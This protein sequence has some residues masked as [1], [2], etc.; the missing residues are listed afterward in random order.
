MS[1]HDRSWIDI[2]RRTFTKW[3]NAHLK[4]AGHRET[5]EDLSRDLQDGKLLHKLLESISNTKLPKITMTPKMR[6]HQIQNLNVCVTFISSKV[7]LQGI[8]AEDICNGDIKLILGMIWMIILRFEIADISVEDMNAKEGLL[9]WCQKKTA[10]YP[11]VHVKNFTD[12]WQDGLAFCAL[13]HKHMPTALDFYAQSK[14]KPLENLELAFSVAEKQ[15]GIPRFFDPEDMIAADERSVM[16]YLLQFFHRFADTRKTEVAGRRISKL[17]GLVQSND[18]MKQAYV[19]KAT[20]L[21]AWMDIK[22]PELLDLNFDNTLA[23]ANGKQD[24][25]VLYQSGV[26]PEKAAEKM[27][28]EGL[29]GNLQ[30]KLR[31]AGR[32]EYVPP[33]GLSPSDLDAKWQKLLEA[34]ALKEKAIRDEIARQE[35]IEEL[36]R[37]FHE[38]KLKLDK[39]SEEKKTFLDQ[40]PV[41]DTLITAQSQIKLLDGYEQQ[42]KSSLSRVAELH[43][44]GDQICQL[45]A[46]VAPE[47]TQQVATV[48]ATWT[49]LSSKCE[50][51]K[52]WLNEELEKQ[53]RMEELRRLFAEKVNSLNKW[54]QD[55]IGAIGDAAFGDTL[56][57]VIAYKEKLDLQEMQL[58]ASSSEK[59]N[60]LEAIAN[61]MKEMGITENK[62]TMLTLDDMKAQEV[63][64][65]GAL[66]K[67]KEAYEAELKRQELMEEKR[68]EFAAAANKFM[69]F[70]DTQKNTIDA[71]NGEPDP[72]TEEIKNQWQEAAPQQEQLDNL[73]RL[74]REE[75]A[76]QITSNKYTQHTVASCASASAVFDAY[77][78]NYL[79][80]LQEEKALKIEFAERAARL[81]A[82]IVATVEKLGDR[83]FDNTLAG[84]KSAMAVFGGYRSGEKPPKT[85]EYSAVLT[86]HATIVKLL[87]DSPHHRPEFVPPEGLAPSDLKQLWMSLEEAETNREQFLTTELKRQERLNSIQRL[88]FEEAGEL[89]AWAEGKK[90]YLEV[91]VAVDTLIS[92]QIQMNLMETYEDDYNASKKKVEDLRKKHDDLVADNFCKTDLVKEKMAAIDASWAELA[93]LAADKKTKIEEQLSLEQRKEEQRLDFALLAKNFKEWVL[94]QCDKAAGTEFGEGLKA[95]EEFAKKLEHKNKKVNDG[96]KERL[97]EIHEKLHSMEELGVTDNVHTSIKSEDITAL[98]QKLQTALADRE[99]K[100]NQELAK[101]QAM[102]NKRIEFANAGLELVA[103]LVNELKAFDEMRGEPEPLT[104]EIK[105]R[106]NNGEKAAAMLAHCNEIYAVALRMEITENKHAKH[107]V[108]S[109]ARQV[110]EYNKFVNNFLSEL[111]NEKNEK[112]LYTEKATKLVEWAK[113]SIEE[114]GSR[115]IDNTLAGAQSKIGES[116]EW[117]SAVK[118]PKVAERTSVE[119]IFAKVNSIVTVSPHHRPEFNPA[120]EI[121]PAGIAA[122]FENLAQAEKE[123]EEFLTKEL[124]RQERL[125]RLARDFNLAGEELKSWCQQKQEYL[126]HAEVVDTLVSSKIQLDLL[127]TFSTE[128]ANSKAQLT[129]LAAQCDELAQGNYCEIDTIKKSLEEMTA[130]WESLKEGEAKKR[131]DL[132]KDEEREEKKEEERKAFAKLASEFDR[133]VR[134]ACDKI[135]KYAFGSSL[136]EVRAYESTMQANDSELKDECDKRMKAIKEVQD[137]MTELAVQDNVYTLLGMKEMDDLVHRVE[138]SIENRHNAYKVELDRQEEM[139]KTRIKFAELVTQFIECL[140]KGKAAIDA[141]T[142]EPEHKEEEIKRV[143]AGGDEQRAKLAD[144]VQLDAVAKELKIIDNK[145]TQFTLPMLRVKMDK[146]EKYFANS[147]AAVEQEKVMKQRKL[148]REAE[149]ALK[150]KIESLRNEYQNEAQTLNQWLDG[151]LEALAGTPK[152]SSEKEVDDLAAQLTATSQ[153][154][155]QQKAL[156]DKVEALVGQLKEAGVNA[157]DLGHARVIENWTACGAAIDARSQW[158]A[159]EK[160]TQITHFKLRTQYAELAASFHN[161]MVEQKSVALSG[162]L[163]V[164]LQ[165]SLSQEQAVRTKGAEFTKQAEALDASLAE[166]HVVGNPLTVHTTKSLKVEL[167]QLLDVLSKRRDLLERQINS[168]KFGGVS[169]EE[170]EEMSALFKQFDKEHT[171][172]LRTYMFKGIMNALGEEMSD[173]EIK[174]V[175]DSIDTNH[176]GFLSF[177]E[178]TTFMTKR[179]TDTDSKEEIIA[180]FRDITNGKDSITVNELSSVMPREQAEW[181]GS[182]MPQKEG[183]LD[184][185]AWADQAFM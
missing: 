125:T 106:Y 12:S 28:A 57:E 83:A 53:K 31:N 8:S 156:Y 37:L 153:E 45:G 111:D 82:W 142:G 124:E 61:Q 26:K 16:T 140:D 4:K 152:V 148:E 104:E 50:E 97:E 51:K 132:K 9:Y 136:E 151:V 64:M 59:Y 112:A 169:P 77:V 78:R 91:V 27:A 81:K 130:L 67:L 147:M 17:V 11:G 56:E 71:L 174:R 84:A 98:H 121:S 3:F 47:I 99:A 35:K 10:G 166:A 43:Q 14:E 13:I 54:Y 87:K 162:E 105:L 103:Y 6:I 69:E 110:N 170:L 163:E 185:T 102:E 175:F 66:A 173:D 44:L 22:I 182:H 114:L 92:A 30:V 135:A 128:Y 80:A 109:L 120:E 55:E 85:A 29:F 179:R 90:H 161:W 100:Y 2:Q 157:D 86:L 1:L 20:S 93:Q 168:K 115:A 101:Q 36:V 107:S 138:L 34:E 178:F 171:G 144:C 79:S 96:A 18:E 73:A 52:Q 58:H 154:V 141:I 122:V 129:S 25:M 7:R 113:T 39:W 143:Y 139:E 127:Q 19:D 75:I 94:Q 32:P 95:V 165:A 183:G 158:L 116:A 123:R 46:K 134:D 155:P 48:E 40:R 146:Y 172:Q 63:N 38:K 23:G 68:K 150:E 89:S 65:N 126:A 181:L 133:W 15:L 42:H 117:K 167:E 176:D 33:G 159:K 177:E 180:A 119:V 108:Q 21:S 60:E 62:Y 131:D 49:D 88:F 149:W 118:A 76:M 41:I 184:Y 74:Y 24:E 164:Q 145:H 160:Q 72:L 137:K 5:V 70:L